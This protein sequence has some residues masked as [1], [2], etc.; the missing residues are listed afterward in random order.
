MKRSFP[1]GQRDARIN[2][3]KRFTL[4][5]IFDSDLSV[6]VWQRIWYEPDRNLGFAEAPLSEA[7][8]CSGFGLRSP[9]AVLVSAKS[10]ETRTLAK[11]NTL[12]EEM[13]GTFPVSEALAR[14]FGEQICFGLQRLHDGLG[15]HHG[16]VYPYNVGWDRGNHQF[17]LW[18]EPTVRMELE[19]TPFSELDPRWD[20]PFGPPETSTDVETDLYG[21]GSIMLRLLLT[22]CLGW[23]L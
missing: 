17:F 5:R 19:N 12:A 1:F 3:M 2:T 16:A 9:F 15:H 7:R 13:N 23:L 21:V 18:S 8:A 22:Y 14:S 10:V 4:E 20:L 11:G 6:P